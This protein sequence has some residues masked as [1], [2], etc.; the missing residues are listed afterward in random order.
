MNEQ[1]KQFFQMLKGLQAES[2]QN[3][4]QDCGHR[5]TEDMLYYATFEMM[6]GLL[7]YLDGYASDSSFYLVHRETGIP[8]K[9]DPFLE[10]HDVMGKYL[11]F[12][13]F[14][15]MLDGAKLLEYAQAGNCLQS[16]GKDIRYL[17][18][19]RYADDN[20]YYLF[21]CNSDRAVVQDDCWDS[22]EECRRIAEQFGVT[23]W[24][25]CI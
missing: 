5:S 22:A 8:L 3:T 24:Y 18:I 14:P 1:Q 7:T 17:A 25:K 10:L 9:S 15:D 2:V 12:Q 20:K 21:Y 13:S 19:C 6:S 4:L 16:T 23:K 11:Q